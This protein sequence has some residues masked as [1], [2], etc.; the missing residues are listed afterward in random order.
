MVRLF[1]R[2]LLFGRSKL[3]ILSSVTIPPSRF[4]SSIDKL[5]EELKRLPGKDAQYRMAP[6]GRIES[7]TT[8]VKKTPRQAG[9]LVL[10]YPFDGR[11]YFPM[12]QRTD[13]GGV[14]AGEIGFPGGEQEES[15]NDLVA[16]ALRESF[17][18]IGIEREKVKIQGRL[19][20]LYIPISNFLVL[21]V[22]GYADHRPEFHLDPEEVEELLEIPL[23]EF[24]NPEIIKHEE[25]QIGN[26][27]RIIP[28]FAIQNKKIWGASAMI[29]SE[30]LAIIARIN[31]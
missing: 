25:R 13:Y 27:P 5:R 31:P 29:L 16:T 3:E 9:V 8:S 7:A 14:H 12:I 24:M 17:E 15:D 23:T 10:F 6:E 30:L 28:Y 2:M 18:E 20:E 19:S 21:P 26:G 1:F 11:L 22:V 4:I